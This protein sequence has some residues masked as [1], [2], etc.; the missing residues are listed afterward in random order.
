MRVGAALP[1]HGRGHRFETRHAHQRKQVPESPFRAWLPADCQQTTL[2]RRQNALSVVRIE[3]LDNSRRPPACKARSAQLVSR[4]CRKRAGRGRCGVVRGCPLGTALARSMWH[5]DGTVLPA[6]LLASSRSGWQ[7][8]WLL[9]RQRPQT[10]GS[11]QVKH[12]AVVHKVG[13]RAADVTSGRTPPIPSSRDH[14]QTLP[15]RRAPHCRTGA[16]LGQP[17]ADR[18]A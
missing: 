14:P 10:G 5:A 1:S 9:G 2:S 17:A 11:R 18:A 8:I 4:D 7:R 15:P 13:C 3:G 6:R 16:A 12:E